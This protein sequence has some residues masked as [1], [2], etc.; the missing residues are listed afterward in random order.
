MNT[1]FNRFWL[2]LLGIELGS[3][4]AVADDP[5]ILAIS[6]LKQP[7]LIMLLLYDV[8]DNCV[9]QKLFGR[10]INIKTRAF[11]ELYR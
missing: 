4:V 10:K 11:S 2:T 1:N 8:H 6:Q 7:I 5:L 9:K 3:P